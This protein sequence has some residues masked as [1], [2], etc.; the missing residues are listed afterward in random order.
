MP[1]TV[2][3]PLDIFQLNSRKFEAYNK[4]LRRTILNSLFGRLLP[5]SDVLK[6]GE[7]SIFLFNYFGDESNRKHIADYYHKFILQKHYGLSAFE[8]IDK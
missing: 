5:S 1:Q 4:Y 3:V 6:M 8:F 7:H 2:L